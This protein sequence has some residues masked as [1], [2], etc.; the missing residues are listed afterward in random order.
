M[1]PKRAEK[2]EVIKIRAEINK[3]IGSIWYLV[4][5]GL[6]SWEV[7]HLLFLEEIV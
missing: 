2:M 1:N 6:M 7:F 3:I 5:A 4:N